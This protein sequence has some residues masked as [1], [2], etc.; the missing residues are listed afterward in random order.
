MIEKPGEKAM[1]EKVGEITR[2]FVSVVWVKTTI[3]REYVLRC[4]ELPLAVVWITVSV[5]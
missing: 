3:Q 1:P 5:G 2:A 4:Q